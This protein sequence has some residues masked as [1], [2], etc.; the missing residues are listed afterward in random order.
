MMLVDLIHMAAPSYGG[1]FL[2]IMRSV[3]PDAD[4]ASIVGW[5]AYCLAHRTGFVGGGISGLLFGI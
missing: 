4:T 3:C 1:D 5:D 2:Q